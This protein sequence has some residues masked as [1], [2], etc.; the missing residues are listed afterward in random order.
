M[1]GRGFALELLSGEDMVI[2]EERSMEC[3]RGIY[4][5][6]LLHVLGTHSKI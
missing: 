5:M 1:V 4:G 6:A 2:V 3:G